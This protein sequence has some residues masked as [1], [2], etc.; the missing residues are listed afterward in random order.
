MEFT[1]YIHAVA[2]GAK[3]NRDLSFD[4][5]FDMMTQMLER[6][7]TPE[8]IAGFLVGWRLKPETTEEFRGALAA[9]DAKI[10]PL[11]LPNSLELGYPF[12]GKRNNP[13]LF[14][15]AAKELQKVG[16]EIIVY[17]DALQPAKGGITT[18]DIAQN[19]TL[20]ENIRYF[21]R[22]DFF[23]A[24]SELTDI[25]MRLGLRSGLNTIEKL[26][27]YGSSESAVIGMFHKPYLKKYNAIFKERYKNFTLVHGNEGTPEIVGKSR[28][29]RVM[30]E[31][32]EEHLI[33]PRAFG[34]GYKK[35]HEPITLEKSLRLIEEP[36][37]DIVRL[38]RLNAAVWMFSMRKASSIEEAF[39][40]LDAEETV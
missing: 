5:A 34:I 14:V 19:V 22:A 25:R 37:E 21:E 28:I 12:D 31:D 29:Y 1:T 24:F 32:I 11:S 39:E 10:T 15:L 17:G 4:E 27:R 35:S 6:R 33:D 38:A 18:R 30:D 7:A 40:R 20:G 8:Q 13:Y 2:T 16:I 23:K 9:C 3:G 36:S 26:P